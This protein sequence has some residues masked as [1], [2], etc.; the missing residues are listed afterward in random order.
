VEREE[1]IENFIPEE[2]WNLNANFI[3]DNNEYKSELKLKDKEKLDSKK[4]S[5]VIQK[6]EIDLL[7]EINFD[8]EKSIIHSNSSIPFKVKSISQ[9]IEFKNPPPPFKTSD[10]QKEA[11]MKLGIS[12]SLAMGIAGNLY[13]GKDI[14]SG[15]KGLITYLRTDSTR[16]SP[17]A[18]KKAM[19]FWKKQGKK[20]FPLKNKKSGSKIQDAH[21][22]IRPTDINLTPQKVKPFLNSLEFKI[23]D[24]IWKR[25]ASA[26]L[27]ASSTEK[28]EILFSNGNIDFLFKNF[29]LIDPGFKEIYGETPENK[30]THNLSEGD[31][32][33]LKQLEMEKKFTDPPS[34]FTESS[35]VAKMEK[36][37]VGR[38]STYATS[39][40]ILYKRNYVV[41]I[42]KSIEP[43]DLGKKVIEELI[44]RFE[45]LLEDNYTSKM[46]D[47]LDKIEEGSLKRTDFLREV[48]EDFHKQKNANPIRKKKMIEVQN[49]PICEKGILKV[50]KTPK[51]KNY[52]ICS[53]FPECDFME[54]I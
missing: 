35:L 41:K 24:L 29:S 48:D 47:F 51:K 2:Y 39:I 16:V 40:D 11:S 42:K 28:T 30:F 32:V 10:F 6:I 23:Y 9:K 12:P 53:R 50:K 34:R 52:K 13:E 46:E 54:Y 14:G 5:I 44:L 7:K 1:E 18:E 37:G 45:Q 19:E 17:S 36:T 26:F 3:K 4:L 31:E 15:K 25:Y 43:T 8:L 27:K 21:E 22:A 38:P 20:S 33:L 49:C